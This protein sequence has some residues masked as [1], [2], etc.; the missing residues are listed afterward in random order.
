[1]DYRIYFSNPGWYIVTS[2]SSDDTGE[3]ECHM[4]G[5]NT[6]EEALNFVKQQQIVTLPNYY[7]I[8][9]L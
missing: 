4:A 2:V 8:R 9:I 3:C 6:Y 5:F 7:G 1:M